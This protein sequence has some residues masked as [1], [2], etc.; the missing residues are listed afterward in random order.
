M[1]ELGT[2][3]VLPLDAEHWPLEQVPELPPAVHA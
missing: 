2:P 1:Q 3:F